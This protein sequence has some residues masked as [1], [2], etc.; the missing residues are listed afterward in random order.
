VI[1]F[2]FPSHK[3]H[4]LTTHIRSRLFISIQVPILTYYLYFHVPRCFHYYIRTN[5]KKNYLVIIHVYNKLI[6]Y[7]Y[8]VA[9]HILN[10]YVESLAC[11]LYIHIYINNGHG[12]LSTARI[13]RTSTLSLKYY[14][15][16]TISIYICIYVYYIHIQ[17][18]SNKVKTN[19]KCFQK[20]LT[21]LKHKCFT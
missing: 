19:L 7:I 11:G 5:R 15:C 1:F 17:G 4:K 10:T 8:L 6:T 21:F 12:I 13:T 20:V 3:S 2:T 16:T 9:R 18:D 14:A